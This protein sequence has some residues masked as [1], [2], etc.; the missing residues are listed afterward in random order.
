MSPLTMKLLWVGGAAAVALTGVAIA[1]AATKPKPQVLTGPGAVNSLT[2][3]PGHR[4]QI[5][6]VDPLIAQVPGAAALSMQNAQQGFDAGFGQGIFSVVSTAVVA[7]S[8]TLVFD[9]KGAQPFAMSAAA[10][11]YSPTT[12]TA[13]I[14]DMGA[15]P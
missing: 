9:Y 6:I 3:Q 12:T 4:Y 10:F 14:T 2:L 7:S 5:L 11:Q 1:V 15:S 8:W 13:T